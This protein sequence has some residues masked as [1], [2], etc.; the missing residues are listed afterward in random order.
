LAFSLEGRVWGS[1]RPLDSDDV[2]TKTSPHLGLFA[3]AMLRHP[4]RRARSRSR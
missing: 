3:V 4:R 2:Q 1:P